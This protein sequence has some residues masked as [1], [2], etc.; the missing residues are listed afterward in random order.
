[1]NNSFDKFWVKLRDYISDLIDSKHRENSLSDFVDNTMTEFEKEYMNG[2]GSKY[3]GNDLI[4]HTLF[5]EHLKWERVAFRSIMERILNYES[6]ITE[7]KSDYESKITEMKLCCERVIKRIADLENKPEDTNHLPV[8]SAGIDREI[9]LP[10]NTLT[11]EGSATDADND[12]MTYKWEKVSGGSVSMSDETKLSL[13]LSGLLSGI[14]KF[15]L[16]ATDSKGASASDDVVVTVKSMQDQDT[17]S[18]SVS[19]SV[20]SF[21]SG[22][23]TGTARAVAIDDDSNL[24]YE[25]SHSC[26]TNTISFSNRFVAN[27]SVTAVND[28]TTEAIIC[29][30]TVKVCDSSNNCTKVTKGI[31]IP[32]KS[33]VVEPLVIKVPAIIP[34]GVSFDIPLS[35]IGG[36]GNY[37]FT[38]SV[39][40]PNELMLSNG[41]TANPH[42]EHINPYLPQMDCNV[43]FKVTDAEDSSK[44]DTKIITLPIRGLTAPIAA[45]TGNTSVKCNDTNNLGKYDIAVVTLKTDQDVSTPSG[46]T[47]VTNRSFTRT[48][49]ANGTK[50]V[51][52]S[53][54]NGSGTASVNISCIGKDS[55]QGM[56][57]PNGIEK[58]GDTYTINPTGGA[59]NYTYKWEVTSGCY[60]LS[61]TT[62]KTV[63][64]SCP[65]NA[66]CTT[67][68][69]RVTV[70]D[71]STT[72]VKNITINKVCSPSYV[73][74]ANP[75]THNIN[76]E[77]DLVNS[78]INSLKNGQ[79]QS[80]TI[81]SKP[82]WLTVTK[83]STGV[84]ITG[85]KNV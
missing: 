21:P 8:V 71:G 17:T 74:T 85:Q 35:A 19:V 55:G 41:N 59:G 48:Y 78:T 69:L 83:T 34:S 58:S 54:E 9:Q 32:P 38:T 67:G 7:M 47:K 12:V 15:R 24:T 16:T 11:L 29:K 72:M 75:N 62:A 44:T 31:T 20:P 73:F 1:M 33:M 18:P 49:T 4:D 80:Y 77:G 61:S 84:K 13:S 43:T 51:T 26:P 28:S 60:K 57:L 36:S 30:L 70:S 79:A 68:N 46:W 23:G 76:C 66:D 37:K 3:D 63:T 45:P 25:W 64:I 5:R 56:E 82:S 42:F 65:D 14:Y 53:N 81:S 40:C 6:K 50:T 39:G 22:G 27:P 10:N 2:K 52:F